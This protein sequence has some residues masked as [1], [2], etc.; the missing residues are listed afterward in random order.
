M[1]YA[2]WDDE[3]HA[4]K[5]KLLVIMDEG[6]VLTYKAGE[7]WASRHNDND[8]GTTVLVDFER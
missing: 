2:S 6:A 4:P 5:V 1:S 8:R 3:G 7:S